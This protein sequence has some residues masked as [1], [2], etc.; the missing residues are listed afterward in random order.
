MYEL[1]LETLTIL[2]IFIVIILVYLIYYC[3]TGTYIEE[4]TSSTSTTT[5]NP[6]STST[7]TNNPS[8][9]TTTP[10]TTTSRNC[11]GYGYIERYFSD[12][13]LSPN[14]T[15]SSKLLLPQSLQLERV[16]YNFLIL[17]Y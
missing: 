5:N 4:F 3:Y 16:V 13:G 11:G 7:T 9:T 10:T 14:G 15:T 1:E 6:S 12:T 2:Q 8:S 17:F